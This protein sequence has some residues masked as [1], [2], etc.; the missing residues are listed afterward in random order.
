[1]KWNAKQWLY[2]LLTIVGGLST[3][4]FNLQ[5]FAA[6][7]DASLGA[8]IAETG[9]TLPAQSINA[10][11]AVASFTFLIWMWIEGRRL[12]MKGLWIYTML[13]FL[14]AFAFSFPLFLLFREGRLRNIESSAV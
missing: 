5:F 7:E 13:T 11:I 9:T 6:A 14:V 4:Y 8:F 10:D 12:K 1:M 2:L 3:W